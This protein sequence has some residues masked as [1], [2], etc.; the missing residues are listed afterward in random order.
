[1]RTRTSRRSS[2]A[3]VVAIVAAMLAGIAPDSLHAQEWSPPRT[4]WH[5]D[6]GH[7]IDGFFLD[8]WR[9]YPELLGLPITEEAERPTQ[10]E[11]LPADIRIVQYFQN[12]AIAYVPEAEE[13]EMMVRALPLGAESLQLDKKKLKELNRPVSVECTESA[14]GDCLVFEKSGHT[15]SA[16]FLEFWQENDGERLIGSPI[17]EAFETSDG[18]MTQY[19]EYVVLRQ[20]GDNPVEPRPVGIERAKTLKLA[21]RSI[22][23]PVSIPKYDERIFVAPVPAIEEITEPG[24]SDAIQPRT[25]L[26]VGSANVGPGPQQGGQKEIVISISA[27]SLWA[28]ENGALVTQSLVSTGTAEVEGT[29]TPLGY[30]TVHLK[31][32]TQTMKG[33]IS[34]EDYEVEDVPWVMYFDFLGN[35]I[36]GTYWHNNFGTP[37]SHGCVN[38]PMDIAEFLYSWAPEGTQVSVIA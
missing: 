25:D 29:V 3:F 11:G 7:T 9:A 18:Y 30:Y 32:V 26:G 8:E 14:V 4:V 36:H 38:L 22:P 17:T 1:M 21:T 24:G 20:R 2:V 35:A 10:I 33:T 16:A 15:L 19:F 6:S 27:Q 12:M 23:Q 37:M 34:N 5:E 28:Y 31:Y 13:R